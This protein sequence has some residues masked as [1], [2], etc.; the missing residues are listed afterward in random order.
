[1]SGLGTAVNKGREEQKGHMS[2][3]AEWWVGRLD[4]CQGPVTGPLPAAGPIQQ[5]TGSRAAPRRG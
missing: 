5:V 3:V 2:D 4:G 1:M